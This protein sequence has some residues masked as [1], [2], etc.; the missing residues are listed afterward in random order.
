MHKAHAL[1]ALRSPRNKG[2]F[3]TRIT[4]TSSLNTHTQ[5]SHTHSLSHAHSL[6]YARAHSLAR[7]LTKSPVEIHALENKLVAFVHIYAI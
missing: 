6:T 5:H 2:Q 4:P 3:A 7:S 1:A